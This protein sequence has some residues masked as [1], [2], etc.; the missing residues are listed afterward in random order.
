MKR[1]NKNILIISCFISLSFFAFK[2]EAA[3]LYFMPQAEVFD[4]GE[5]FS[6]DL[7]INSEGVSIN[8]VQAKVSFS[9]GILE[10][11]E[12]DRVDSIFN[13]WMEEPV[14][15]NEEGT[16]V[17][18]GGSPK[19][20]S[21][22]TLQV[23]RMKFRAKGNGLAELKFLEGV[24]TASDGHGTNVLYSIEKTN[25][26]IGSD[27]IGFEPIPDE[28][29]EP[30]DEPVEEPE[31][32]EREPV[33]VG[34]LPQEP[35]L[36]VPLYPDESRWYNHF[37]ETIVLWEM[38]LDII[39][40]ET[41][42]SKAPDEKLGNI[43]KELFTGKNFGILEEGISYLRIQFKNNIGWGEFAYYKISIDTTP[44]LPFEINID[45]QVSDNP[46]PEIDYETQDS[47]SGISQA[48]IYIDANGPIES[49]ET[50]MVLPI[51]APGKHT[52]LVRVFD[53]AGNSVE[54]DLEFEV[55]PLPTPTISFLTEK[56]SQGDLIFISGK[57]VPNGF[58]DIK[59]SD[60]T[61]QEA[62]IEVSP[63]DGLGNWEIV[64]ENTLAKGEYILSVSARDNRGAVSYPAPDQV[65]KVKARIILSIGF[66]ELSWF[67]VFI[68][69][70]LLV[71]S[72][73]SVSAWYYISVKKRRTAYKM[74]AA[75]DVDKLTTLFAEDLK[76]LESWVEK[77]KEGFEKRTGPEMEFH[78]RSMRGTVDKMRKYLRQELDKL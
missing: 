46:M 6:V 64:L 40:V 20:I 50:S 71:V 26:N 73:I 77:S 75:R 32:V 23:L 34:N 4:Q 60:E 65:I 63:S 47:L 8:A 53:F 22:E 39:E 21:G 41:K 74:I 30:E 7:K 57:A 78:L 5:E 14:I 38:P 43:E 10:L 54:D 16:L 31:K 29:S 3:V 1:L 28:P 69:G 25:I 36:R 2:V 35:K 55:L 12:T 67:E 76:G 61:G 70:I 56:I 15:S 17:F 13:F 18:I 37:G 52:L 72:I 33:L 66:I 19:G 49:S 45:S 11:L 58:V 27:L 44:P 48:L 59:V 42:L 62:I 9:N 68:I 51:Q 24:V